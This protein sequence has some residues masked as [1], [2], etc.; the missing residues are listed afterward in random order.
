MSE[1]NILMKM[2]IEKRKQIEGIICNFLGH[3]PDGK[4][5]K[6]FR[7]MHQLEMCHVYYKTQLIGTVINETADEPF[8]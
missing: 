2:T 4:E 8:I 3:P 1:F 5:R 7:M 6:N